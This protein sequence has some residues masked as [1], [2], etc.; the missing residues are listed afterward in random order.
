LYGK[1]EILEKMPPFLTGGDMITKVTMKNSTWNKLPW[2][3][4]AGTPNVA[5][6]AGLSAA[7]DYI[8]KI[9]IENIE[10]HCQKLL[11]YALKKI[12]NIE[13]VKTY[14]PKG[15]KTSIIALNLKGI[16]SHDLATILDNKGI[17][18]R[19]GNHCAQP[20]LKELKT[21]SIARASFYIYNTKQE[22]DLLIE[23]I[24]ETKKIFGD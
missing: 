8:Q 11:E 9:K 10:E 15:P 19:S 13:K 3:F 22:I 4:E 14:T 18:I 5:G 20:L 12:N 7:I 23:G 6:A 17:I 24:E 2:K 1:K 16:H 21:E